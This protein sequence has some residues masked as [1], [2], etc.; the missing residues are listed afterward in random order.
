MMPLN[1]R[2]ILKW[3][4]DDCDGV[5]A[6]AARRVGLS[7]QRFGQLIAGEKDDIRLSTLEKLANAMRVEPGELIRRARIV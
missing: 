3:I 7:A 5:Q 4:D 6:E 2:I 1:L